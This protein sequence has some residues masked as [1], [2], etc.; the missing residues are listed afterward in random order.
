MIQIFIKIPEGYFNNQDFFLESDTYSGHNTHANIQKINNQI[1]SA[2]KYFKNIYRVDFVKEFD[3]NIDYYFGP[4]LTHHAKY[5]Q[6]LN[7]NP[8]KKFNLQSNVLDKEI[9]KNYI[10]ILNTNNKKVLTVTIRN[11]NDSSKR[12]S[13]LNE[14][15]KAI[16]TLKKDFFVVLVPD[17]S[18]LTNNFQGVKSYE[19]LN[20][21]HIAIE[22]AINFD[23]RLALYECADLNLFVNNGPC[24]VATLSNDVKFLM[25]KILVD[26]IPHAEAPFLRDLGYVINENP[27]YLNKKQKYVW[28]DDTAEN[29]ISEVYDFI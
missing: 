24:V 29:I 1:L 21:N 27:K 6:I 3:Y 13:N 16:Q 26:G 9:I 4:E 19:Y 11:Y 5:Y 8:D 20:Y 28:K 14:W 10:Q 12:N 7:F 22:A 2:F 15:K 23:I 18:E 25:F 17:S